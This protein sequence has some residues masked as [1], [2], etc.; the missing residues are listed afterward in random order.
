MARSKKATTSQDVFCLTLPLRHE[1][2]QRDRLDN[3]FQCCNHVKIER[4]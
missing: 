1:P 4:R 3:L 2:W